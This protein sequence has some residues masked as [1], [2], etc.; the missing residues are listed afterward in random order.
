MRIRRRIFLAAW[1][2]LLPYE[3]AAQTDSTLRPFTIDHRKALLAH[4]PVDVSFLL[5][6][7]QGNMVSF[8]LRARIW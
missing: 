3:V 1:L 8:E 7:L 6:A 2:L 4:S 5:D